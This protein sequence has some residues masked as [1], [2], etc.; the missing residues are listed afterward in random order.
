MDSKMTIDATTLSTITLLSGVLGSILTIV[1]TKVLDLFQKSKEHKYSLQ[2]AFFERKLNAAETATIQFQILANA[3]FSLSVLFER[4]NSKKG[5]DDDENFLDKHL[6]DQLTLQTEVANNASFLIANS[7]TLYFDLDIAFTNNEKIRDFYEV[8]GHMQTAGKQA[9]KDHEIYESQIG[10]QYEVQAY[11]V[12]NQSEKRFE[13]TLKKIAEE[14]K[15]FNQEIIKVL[16]EMRTQ[17]K[18][19]DY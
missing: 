10:N 2:K 13:D 1:L 11:E 5:Q 17:M 12:W 4:L 6:F 8:L 18:K 16:R 14:Y 7:V 19:F 9:Q 3:C 15:T